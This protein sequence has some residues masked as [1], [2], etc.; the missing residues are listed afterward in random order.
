M[1]PSPSVHPPPLCHQQWQPAAWGWRWCR[2]GRA[3]APAQGSAQPPSSWT[4][5]LIAGAGLLQP[6]RQGGSSSAL[7]RAPPEATKAALQLLPQLVP[8]DLPASNCHTAAPAPVL[9]P[10]KAHHPSPVSHT[11]ASVHT[12]SHAR[13]PTAFHAVRQAPTTPSLTLVQ[14]YHPAI[15]VQYSPC[16]QRIASLR[17]RAHVC[18]ELQLVGGRPAHIAA[19]VSGA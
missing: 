10:G 16:F 7:T 9:E 8:S 19:H 15:R 6:T 12:A 11:P 18:L 3:A 17:S 2:E 4:C 1:R 14:R 5:C 13:N